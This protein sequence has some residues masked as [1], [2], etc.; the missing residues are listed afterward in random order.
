[1][2]TAVAATALLAACAADKFNAADLDQTGSISPREFDAYMKDHVFTKIDTN[3]D[4]MITMEEWRAVAPNHPVSKFKQADTNG[5]GMIS[6]TEADKASDKS[7]GY[8]RLFR[9]I[10]TDKDGTL[11]RAEIDAFQA[12]AARQPGDTKY[13]QLS[14]AASSR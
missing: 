5:D 7:G 3:G 10:D 12:S 1:M 13:E 4:G 8:A 2:S 14:S 11:S 6:R 9:K